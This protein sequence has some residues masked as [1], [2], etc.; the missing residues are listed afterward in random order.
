MLSHRQDEPVEYAL[1]TV[2]ATYGSD[3]FGLVWGYFFT[4]GGPARP[5]DCDAAAQFLGNPTQV[6]G[7]FLWLHFS[8]SNAASERWLRQNLSLPEAFHESLHQAVG[9]TRLEQDGDALLAVIHDVLFD[10]TFDASDVSTVSLCVEPRVL[11]SARPRPLRSLDRLRASV[12]A[13]ATFRSPAELLAQL[14]RDQANVLVEIVRQST[15]RVD[16][17]EDKLLGNRIAASRAELGSLRRVLVRLQRLLAPEP[18]A[19]FRLLS[20]PPG[21][22]GEEDLQDLREAAEEFSTVVADSAALVE[23]IKLLQEELAAQIN[24]Q[25][26]R[27]LFVLT[28]VTVLAVP[29]NLIAGLFGMNVGGIPL[30]RAPHGFALIVALVAGFTALAAVLILRRRGGG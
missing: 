12:K 9:S 17:I 13:G 18:A 3:K 6:S 21:W 19:L 16:N 29:F 11:V 5:V 26:N 25:N 28:V 24:E 2:E 22:I 10:F 8:L 14:L 27:I 4:P 1:E 30:E 15:S 20:R 7:Q 23:R